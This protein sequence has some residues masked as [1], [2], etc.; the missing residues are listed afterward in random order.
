MTGTPSH[1]FQLPLLTRHADTDPLLTLIVNGKET[2]F[3]VDTG[4]TRSTLS[5]LEVP[6]SKDT[7]RILTASGQPHTLLV[8]KPLKVQ[9]STDSSSL[10]HRFLL[11]H[12]C[13][14][15][16]LGRDLMT[17]LSVSISLTEQGFYCSTPKLLCQISPHPKPSFAAWTPDISPHTLLLKALHSFPS[18]LYHHLQVPDTLHCTAQYFPTEVDTPWLESFLSSGICPE[19][20]HIPC[21]F[22]SSTKAAASVHLTYSQSIFY[23]G[24]SVPHMSLAKSNTVR[25]VELG[26]WVEQCLNRTDWLYV[27]PGIFDTPDHLI[28]KVL[29]QIDLPVVRSLCQPSVSLCSLQTDFFPWLSSIPDTLWSQGKNNFGRIINCEPL[30]VFPKSSFRPRRAQYPLSPE[31][32]LGIAAVHKELVERGAIIPIKYSPVNS[33]ILPVK[34]ADGSWRFVQ[35]LRQVNSAIFPRAPIVPNPSTILSTI[36]ATVRYFSVIDLANAFFSIP[37]HPDSQF[38]FAFTF[39]NRRWTWTVMPQGYTE[40][41]C[42]Y[43]QA[44]AQNLEGFWPDRESA[45]IQ[46]VDDLL[47]CSETEKACTQDTESLLKYLAENGHKVSKAK[48]QLVQTTVKYLGHDITCGTRALSKDRITTIQNLPRPVTKQQVMSVL[49]ILGY[50]RQ[51]ILNFSERAQPLQNLANTADLPLS[52]RIQWNE[53]AEKALSDFKSALISAPALGLPDYSR[54]FTLFV[55][56]KGGYMNAVLTQLHGD[57][58]RPIAYFSKKLDPVATG[59]PTCLRAVAATTEAV[60]ASTDIVLM[61]PLTVKVPH[62]VHSILVQAKTSHLTTARAIHY[63]NVLCTLSNVTIERCTTLNP[64]TLLPTEEEGE[65]HNCHDEITKVLKPR[66]DLQETPLEIGEIIFVDGCSLRL[67]NGTPSTSYAVVKGD[68]LLEANRISSSFSAQAAELIALTRACQLSEG[69]VITIYT[70]SRYAFG[71]CHDHGALWKL[72]GFKTSTG[73]PIQHQKLVESL[74]EAITKPSKLAIVKCQAH[75]GKQDP[76]S[77]GNELAD[78]FAEQ[79]AYNNAPISLFLQKDDKDPDNQI[80]SLQSAATDREKRK[81]FKEGSLSNG[82]WTHKQNNKPFLPK[83]SFPG[84]AKVAHGLD[85]AG[86]DAM[87]QDVERHWEAVGFSTYADAVHYVKNLM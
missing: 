46:Y 12:L 72:R 74:L 85:H 36:P 51:W 69:K 45:L 86:K 1:S 64:A 26:E 68:H 75:T 14:V 60:L 10:T 70:D 54:P 13:P 11:N 23:L 59:L 76:V 30:V 53:Q 55:D 28:T 63:Q 81:W 19:T 18:C 20:L 83:A 22:I 52:G 57:K 62:A 40:A 27:A 38:W 9:L 32:E 58:Q 35:D 7:V 77:K 73:K 78:H 67:E 87:V 43:G 82:V 44:L 34:K 25:W 71:V 37:V 66:P 15:N 33:P 49:G 4:A 8:S 39:Q 80:I 79:A 41:P 6:A 65:P 16:L 42:V 50:C 47:L 5:L 29:I 48:L 61:S 21:I 56:E 24:G 84:M 31:A 17:K 3:L 2:V